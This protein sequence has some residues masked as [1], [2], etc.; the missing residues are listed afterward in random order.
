MDG[1]GRSIENLVRR[2]IRSV[3]EPSADR[4]QNSQAGTVA[5]NCHG[6][7]KSL[8]AKANSLTAKADQLGDQL[9]AIF[10]PRGVHQFSLV[11]VYFYRQFYSLP[12]NHDRRYLTSIILQLMRHSK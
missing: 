2:I 6:K 11:F 3:Q 5:H 9:N 1:D 12:K 7:R 8:T 4:Q 10:L